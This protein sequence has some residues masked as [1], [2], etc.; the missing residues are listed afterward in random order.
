MAKS[1]R[2]V[3]MDKLSSSVPFSNVDCPSMTS[4]L[5]RHTLK[6]TSSESDH[7]LTLQRSARHSILYTPSYSTY[8][9][10]SYNLGA[11]CQ[12]GQPNRCPLLYKT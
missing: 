1:Q 5:G 9:C 4:S 7:C 3:V 10:S 8:N 6:V 2:M 11:C 12:Y